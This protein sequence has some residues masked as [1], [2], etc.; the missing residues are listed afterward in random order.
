RVHDEFAQKLRENKYILRDFSFDEEALQKQQ[1]ELA[2]IEIQEKELWNELL[3]L[4]R[5]NFSEAFQAF[6]HLKVVR[7]FVE[8]V[9]RYGPP[10]EFTGVVILPDVKSTKR[11][12]TNL[13]SQFSYLAP[14]SKGS[15]GAKGASATSGDPAEVGGE[16]A[17][18]M[19]EEFFDFVLMEVPR[20]VN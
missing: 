17:A 1:Q 7:L 10:A 19:E 16:Y 2:S 14:R 9:L 15:K 4:S 3:T 20:V 6:V 12:L 18:L 5:T 11:L 13:Q 8:S